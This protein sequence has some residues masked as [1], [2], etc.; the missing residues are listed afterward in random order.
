MG[1]TNTKQ[2]EQIEYNDNDNSSS[3]DVSEEFNY[4][5]LDMYTTE[6]LIHYIKTMDVKRLDVVED[7]EKLTSQIQ[8]DSVGIIQMCIEFYDKAKLVI[9]E[10]VATK[11][12]NMN[13]KKYTKKMYFVKP[14]FSKEDFLEKKSVHEHDVCDKITIVLNFDPIANPKVQLNMNKITY[15][16]FIDSFGEFE[17]KRDMIG[18][19]KKMLSKMS[20]YHTTRIINCYN[21]MLHGLYDNH[22]CFGKGAFI[23]KEAKK[24]PKNSVD[25]FREIVSIPTII[26]HF[27]RILSLR[28]TNYFLKNSYINTNIQKGAISGIKY[29]V[30]EQ[31][32]KVKEIIKHANTNNKQL[33]LAFLDV[34]NAFGSVDRERLF[35]ILRYYNVDDKIISYIKTYYNNFKYYVSTKDWSTD[36]I[37]FPNGLVQGCPLSSILFVIV[38]NY[39]LSYVNE[40]YGKEYGYD[41]DG[42]SVLFTAYV[43]DVCILAKD[44]QSL[45]LTYNKLKFLYECIGLKLNNTKSAIMK[46]NNTESSFDNI[47]IVNG[48]T[49][50]GEYITHDGQVVATFKAF[51]SMLQRKLSSIDK[52]KVDNNVKLGFFAKCMV[53]WIQRKMMTLYDITQEN[54]TSVIRILKTYMKKWGNTSSMKIFTFMADILLN[55]DD[56]VIKKIG[57]DKMFDEN[58]MTNIDLANSVMNDINIDMSYTSI[59]KVPKPSTINVNDYDLNKQ[60]NN[61]K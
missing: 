40:K 44:M 10:Y 48:Y 41:L 39:V 61:L 31:V 56:V 2:V 5:E 14:R 1:L 23:Y 7:F 9:P 57:F 35:E 54:R 33:C 15:L 17:T 58:L 3:C 13:P 12:D 26:S 52:K 22:S 42:V 20:L 34:S 32:Y 36:L 29:G 49:Y 30:L 4:T 59:N 16:E 25:S 37:D 55:T 46:I 51:L 28:L 53:P 45:E 6:E 60:I 27:H 47:P 38:L 43:D 11:E 50:L 21:A 8:I 18:I 19:S 24:G